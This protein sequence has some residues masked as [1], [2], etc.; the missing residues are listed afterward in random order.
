M[1]EEDRRPEAAPRV[2]GAVDWGKVHAT[3]GG[4]AESAHRRAEL[5]SHR[6]YIGVPAAKPEEIVPDED[7]PLRGLALYGAL[8]T[9]PGFFPGNAQRNPV[10]AYYGRRSV[11]FWAWALHL[12][13]WAALLVLHGM[14]L[15]SN[16]WL[17]FLISFAGMA[18]AVWHPF[19][20]V[21]AAARRGI[22][23]APLEQ[24]RVSRIP[25][26][27]FVQGV[28]MRPLAIQAGALG[29]CVAGEILLLFAW[30]G[31]AGPGASMF[32]ASAL[33][34][35]LLL[36]WVLLRC[37]VE[38]ASAVAARAHFC[39]REIPHAVVRGGFDASLALGLVMGA[40]WVL[41]W[42]ARWLWG[43]LAP[44]G[45][46]VPFLS[47]LLIILAMVLA[48]VWLG[49]WIVRL[50][51]IAASEAMAWVC[52]HPEEWWPNADDEADGDPR[53]V[54][55]TVFSPWKPLADEKAPWTAPPPPRRRR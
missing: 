55:R 51:T 1:T 31:T 54:R 40:P 43:L 3:A 5:L 26:S 28:A 2:G 29:A 24:I 7:R 8:L 36:R 30:L 39:L 46:I 9:T 34:L 17:V 4:G 48:S 27:D 33:L 14:A 50:G 53:R 21:G 19:A 25:A 52:L 15:W 10:L 38:Y 35:F 11:G 16:A 49:L 22:E 32:S 37:L 45:Q 42:L 13:P 23:R 18:V 20:M 12:A 47:E 44:I 6:P 41:A